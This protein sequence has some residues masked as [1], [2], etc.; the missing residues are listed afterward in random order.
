MAKTQIVNSN[1][2]QVA[3]NGT[4]EVPRIPVYVTSTSKMKQIKSSLGKNK[5]KIKKISRKKIHADW[6]KHFNFKRKLLVYDQGNENVQ[7]N[8]MHLSIGE[9]Q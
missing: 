6:N 4:F 1:N 2:L 9:N 3:Q 5:S 8:I 7:F